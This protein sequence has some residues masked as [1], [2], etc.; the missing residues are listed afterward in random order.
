MS[1]INL[2]GMAIGFGVFITMLSWIRFDARFDT[3]H[4]DIDKMYVLNIRL[5]MNGSEYTA[6]RTGGIYSSVLKELFPQV[7]NSCRV[8]QPMEFEMGIPLEGIDADVPMKYYDETM[9]VM[10]DSNFF[11]Y[12]SFSLV[13]GDPARARHPCRRTSRYPIARTSPP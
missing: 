12:F 5:N 13:K 3:F 6:Q 10:V 9:V 2:L 7:E 1:L 4:E 8:S 11:D